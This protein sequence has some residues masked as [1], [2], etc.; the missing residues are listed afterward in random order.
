MRKIISAIMG[1]GLIV[2]VIGGCSQYNDE[3]GKGD[4]PVEGRSGDDAPAVVINMPNNFANIAFKCLNGN[5]L[6]VTT[7]EAAPVIVKDDANCD[8]S[9]VKP[10]G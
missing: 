1:V 5:G 8:G 7:R 2:G 10:L 9:T 3:R 4:A 6:Y